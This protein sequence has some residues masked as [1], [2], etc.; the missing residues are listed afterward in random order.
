MSAQTS[1]TRNLRVALAG[2][3]YAQAPHDIISRAIET[4]AGAA[5]GLAVSRG[6]DK[7]EQ[8]VIGGSDF[9]GFTVRA[10]DTEGAAN[11]GAIKYNESES[12]A[13]L[14]LGYIWAVC[15]TGCVPGD[16]VNYVIATGA[17]DSGAAVAGEQLID[18][19][20]W[21]SS[22]SAGQLAIIRINST[23]TTAGV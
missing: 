20:Q 22:A 9:L 14:R 2:L 4:V 12:A 16:L 13:I 10:L 3:V 15:P 19:A 18:D 7:D 5:F 23:K 8:A 6:T 21:D 11:T 1:Y 17:V